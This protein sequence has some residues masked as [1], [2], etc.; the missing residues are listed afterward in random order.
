LS[1]FCRK[2]HMRKNKILVVREEKVVLKV[3]KTYKN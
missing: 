1:L 2:E 3:D